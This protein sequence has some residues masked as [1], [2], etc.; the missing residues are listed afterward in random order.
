QRFNLP[1]FSAVTPDAGG[2]FGFRF[3]VST[4][5]GNY[6]LYALA[7]IEN[8]ARVPYT[9]TAYSLGLVRGVAVP[10]G[11]TAEN[12]FLR[13]DIPLDHS[14]KL[15]VTGPKPTRRGPDRLEVNVSIR[16]GTEG[17]V[18]LPGAEVQTLL[19]DSTE[20]SV[21]GVPPLVRALTGS[22]YVAAARAVTGSSGAPPRSVLGLVGVTSTAVPLVIAPF[23]EVP[24]LTVPETNTVWDGRELNW[25]A[26]PGGAEPDLVVADIATA[27]GLYNWRIVAPGTRQDLQLPELSAIDPDLAWPR[28]GQTMTVNLAQ[29]ADFDYGSLR[30]RSLDQRGWMAYA[31][32]AFFATY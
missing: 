16:V 1:A 25:T 4:R 24:V 10:A 26:A 18:I 5:P 30:Y 23:L 32:D 11:R 31:T 14:L 3:N 9:F 7:G 2:D 29:V 13:I 17:Y 12:V 15:A 21:V 6:T 20:L 22:T 27:G 19:G 28:G 8:R